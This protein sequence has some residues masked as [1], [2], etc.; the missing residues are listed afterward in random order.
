MRFAGCSVGKD[1]KPSRFDEASELEYS[2]ESVA[3]FLDM[4]K[5]AVKQVSWFS[6]RRQITFDTSH[7]CPHC[8]GIQSIEHEANN[9][10]FGQIPLQCVAQ[11]GFDG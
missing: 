3:Y 8:L 2:I 11:D 4:S 5:I 10:T 6:A 1:H 7:E 9:G